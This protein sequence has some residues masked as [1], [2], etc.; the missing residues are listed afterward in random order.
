MM[1]LQREGGVQIAAF[2]D[3]VIPGCRNPVALVGE[4]CGECRRAFGPMLRQNPAEKPLTAQEITERDRYVRTAY[5]MQQ[6]V[7]GC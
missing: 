7:A 3:C 2:P 6:A 4:P 5:A 1:P